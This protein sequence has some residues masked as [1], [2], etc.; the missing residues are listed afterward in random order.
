MCVRE[1]CTVG[2]WGGE[3][4]RGEVSQGSTGHRIPEHEMRPS[5]RMFGSSG[6][7]HRG[8]DMCDQG[9]SST[10]F[11]AAPPSKVGASILTEKRSQDMAINPLTP[12]VLL[13]IHSR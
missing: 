12:T 5:L 6:L 13:P 2:G 4:L 9:F 1:G 3:L 7:N 11:G 8:L 10:L